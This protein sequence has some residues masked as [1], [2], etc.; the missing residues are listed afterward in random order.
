MHR[1]ILL[2]SLFISTIAQAE[3]VKVGVALRFAPE[4][5]SFAADL[6]EGIELAAQEFNAR[7]SEATRIELVK[8]PHKD[9]HES[10]ASAGR[11]VIGDKV[12]YVLGAEM[13]DDAFALAETFEGKNVLLMTATATNPLLTAGHPFVFRTCMSD[14]QVATLLAKYVAN[15]KK[16]KSIG[17]LHNTSNAYSDYITNAFLDE[18]EKSKSGKSGAEVTE[19]R[20]ASEHPQFDSAVN[21]FKAKQVDLVV[22]FTL[23]ESIKSFQILAQKA[24]F[25]PEYLGSD[26]WGPTDSLLKIPGFRGIRNDYWNETSG[27][28]SVVRFKRAFQKAHERAPNSSNAAAYDSA[29]VLFDAIAR[30]KKKTDLNEVAGI[31]RNSSFQNAVTANPIRFSR[32]NSPKKPLYLYEIKDGKSQFLKAVE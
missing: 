28:G 18:L 30:A 4:K 1:F 11:K 2:A 19:F 25:A 21:Q 32:N 10:V 9:G 12:Q 29:L 13:S 27:A 26:G 22:A 24:G 3:T 15:L 14:D 31:L 20:Y 23:Q 16:I 8:Y 5:N 17:V 7:E 6:Y